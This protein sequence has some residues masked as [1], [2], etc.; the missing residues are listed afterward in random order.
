[1]P[2]F[3]IA[4]IGGGIVGLAIA[5]RLSEKHSN[6]VLLEKNEKYGMET[7]S[8]NS[9]VIHAGIY[10]VPGSFKAKFCTEGR[11]ELYSICAK[12]NIPHKRITKIITATSEA[13]LPKLESIYRNGIANGVSL[14]FIDGAA[15]KRLEPNIL[16]YRAIFSPSTGIINVHSLMD[17][18]YHT[19]L[20]NSVIV[21]HRCE[22]KGVEKINGGYELVLMEDGRPS[23]IS[24]EIIINAAGLNSDLVAAMAGIDIDG[25]KYRMVYAK[26]SY[27]TVTPAKWKMV[28][29][30]VYPVPTE[31]TLGV[32]ALSDMGGRLRFGPDQ[33]YLP[34]RRFDYTVDDNKRSNF[35]KSVQRIIPGISEEDLTPDMCGIRPKLQRQGEPA[36]DYVIV[37]EKERG[38]EGLINL[39]GIESPGLTSSPAI[40]RYVEGLIS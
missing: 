15:A 7:S 31:E 12:N 18:F 8:R 9:E 6:I 28:S 19:A 26:G 32:H 23:K 34:T 36:R 13:Q 2:D 33:E 39:I 4:I 35:A 1:M 17:H 10:Y 14:E 3:H 29:R 20:K 24:A 5:S 21:Q 25:A 27:F 38:L 40:A 30:L 22:V 11:D 37:H 16:S